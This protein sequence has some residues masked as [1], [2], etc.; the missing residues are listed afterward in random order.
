MCCGGRE[1]QIGGVTGPAAVKGGNMRKNSG[2][3]NQRHDTPTGTCLP[4]RPAAACPRPLFPVLAPHTHHS[5]LAFGSF[6]TPSSFSTTPSTRP[7]VSCAHHYSA[8]CWPPCPLIFP[9]TPSMP[10]GQ[11]LRPLADIPLWEPE[12]ADNLTIH[13]CVGPT[14]PPSSALHCFSIYTTTSDSKTF[15][16]PG[17]FFWCNGSLF[18]SLPPNSNIPCILVTLIPQLTLYSMAEFLELQPP[19]PS[20][21]KRAAFLPIMVGISLT[22][23]AIRAGF[24][25]GALGH[26][27]WAIKYLNAKLEGALTSTADSLASLQRQV[28]LLAKVTLQNR[29][30]LD[31]LKGGTCVFLREECCYYINES[32][33]AETDITKLTD[34]ASSLHSASN[35][36]PFSSILTNPLLTRLWPIAGPI[37]IIPL[38]ACLFLP[39]IIKFIKSH[40]GKISNQTF[41]Q[42]LL[43]N[44]QL[45]PTE[46]P[47]PSRDLLTT[48]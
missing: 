9:T 33:I 30:A 48:R 14:P 28:T 16:Q 23:S 42:L 38:L 12:Y 47:S 25:G 35:S 22:T 13:H 31:L 10:E 41:N 11:P 5:S 34:L 21:T 1:N 7:I 36:N 32:S 46:D 3:K 26:S 18:N 8:H 39:C 20:R 43:R 24:L 40:V 29:W 19:L 2:V 4:T 27:L 15:T 45:L 17:H 44:Y 6:K 37:I